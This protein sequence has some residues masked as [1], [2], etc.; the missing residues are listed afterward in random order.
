MK[1]GKI[2]LVRKQRFSLTLLFSAFV[3]AVILAAIAIAASAVYIFAATGILSS[4]GQSID[5]GTTILLMIGISLV[6]G[7]VISIL[8]RFSRGRA[9]CFMPN[10]VMPSLSIFFPDYSKAGEGKQAIKKKYLLFSEN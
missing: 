9:L 2:R 5:L 4:D 1:K 10:K 8:L 7:W 6:I 3:F